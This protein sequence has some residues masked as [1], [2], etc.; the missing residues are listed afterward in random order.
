MPSAQ[1]DTITIRVPMR[2]KQRL[3]WAAEARGMTMNKMITAMLARR[4][5][6]MEREGKL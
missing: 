6:Q 2:L 3:Q 5:E 4:V 1:T